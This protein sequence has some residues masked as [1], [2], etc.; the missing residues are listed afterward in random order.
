MWNMIVI[1]F[2]NLLGADGQIFV[3]I[4]FSSILYYLFSWKAVIVAKYY[5]IWLDSNLD[6]FYIDIL[7]QFKYHRSLPLPSYT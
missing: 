1:F 2:S 7:D 4:N 3:K 6:R 5:E